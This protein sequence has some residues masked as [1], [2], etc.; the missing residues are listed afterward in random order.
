MLLVLNTALVH[1]NRRRYYQFKIIRR[2]RNREETQ[3]NEKKGNRLE[4]EDEAPTGAM[5]VLTNYSSAHNKVNSSA[6]PKSGT[7]PRRV[8]DQPEL[9]FKVHFHKHA[10]FCSANLPDIYQT[11]QEGKSTQSMR[12]IRTIPY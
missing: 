12:S 7:S 1:I 5:Q 9:P 2:K 8:E 11:L 10:P 4:Q 6:A 3:K